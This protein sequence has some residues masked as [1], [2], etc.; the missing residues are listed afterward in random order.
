[1]KSLVTLANYNG[2]CSLDVRL[3]NASKREAISLQTDARIV[4][5][6]RLGK[7]MFKCEYCEYCDSYILFLL[8]H[9]QCNKITLSMLIT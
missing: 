2:P 4:E 3:M 7:Q 9:I 6:M 8:S 1:M 5:G